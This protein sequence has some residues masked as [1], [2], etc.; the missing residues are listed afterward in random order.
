MKYLY[1]LL[2]ITGITFCSAQTPVESTTK[3]T[4]PKSS[5]TQKSMSSKDTSKTK[6]ATQ[7]TP[8]SSSAK[9]ST[10]KSTKMKDST[11]T[12]KDS[13]KH[14]SDDG[15]MYGKTNVGPGKGYGEGMT[16]APAAFPGGD[17][18]LAVFLSRNFKYLSQGQ[19][20]GQQGEVN[21]GFTIDKTGKIQNAM[22][23]KGSGNKEVDAEAVRVVSM[24]PNWIPGMS[25]GKPVEVQYIL[26]ISY[27]IPQ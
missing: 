23:L 12:S 2:L 15:A 4:A 20:N 13:T 25:G 11:K 17:D 6:T 27:F 1:L 26:P 16:Q 21:V 10:P 9:S 19:S 18:S 14:S 3:S 24:M 22:V 8:K 7:S 5:T